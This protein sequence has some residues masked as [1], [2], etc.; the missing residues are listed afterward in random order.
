MI[1]IYSK[2]KCKYDRTLIQHHQIIKYLLA[3][4]LQLSDRL[5][6]NRIDCGFIIT[7]LDTLYQ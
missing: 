5:R 4:Y 1:E 7:L 6:P 3:V 2:G